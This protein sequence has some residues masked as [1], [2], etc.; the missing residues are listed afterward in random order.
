METASGKTACLWNLASDLHLWSLCLRTVMLTCLCLYGLYSDWPMS[1]FAQL[2]R[3]SI[4]SS[5]LLGQT[6]R[7][8][9]DLPQLNKRQL[10]SVC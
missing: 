6:G 9:C 3:E 4:T 1:S 8:L 5:G 10:G 2:L 7:S